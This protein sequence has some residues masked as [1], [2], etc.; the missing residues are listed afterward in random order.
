MDI[1]GLGYVG[2]SSPNTKQWLE[3]G[4][5]VMGFGVDD[6]TEDETVL[7]RMDQHTW[8]LAIHPGPKNH[9][10]Y[11]G[12]ELKGRRS[13]ERA[14]ETLDRAGVSYTVGDDELRAKRQVHEIAQF[15]DPGGIP[16]EIF[17]GLKHH[18][19]SFLPGRPMNGFVA[20]TLGLGHC[21]VVVPEYTK[22]LE[23]FAFEVL[24]F[25]WFGYGAFRGSTGFFRSPHNPRSHMIGYM[26]V[27]GHRG[28][29]H[30]GI[31]VNDIDDVGVAWDRT[32]ERGDRIMFTL[33]R[34]IQDPVISF[35]T[36]TPGG[37]IVEYLTGGYQIPDPE[38][39]EENPTQLSVW[40]HKP[41]DMGMPDTVEQLD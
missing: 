32:Q 27:P 17:F 22:E 34:H 4:P 20:G 33:G 41:L 30:L 12:W 16:M 9:L 21:V 1:I 25:E 15:T 5:E 38:V 6:Q 24:G 40:G 37:F 7:L 19:H 8:R 35:Y 31:E 39:V 28:L 36:H 18:S 11:I 26:G 14:I 23:D 13:F 2:V 10:E 29:H 3:Y